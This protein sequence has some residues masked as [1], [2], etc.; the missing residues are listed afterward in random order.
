MKDVAIVIPNNI[1]FCPFVESYKIVLNRLKVDY[2]IISWNRDGRVEEGIQY[3]CALKRISEFHIFMEYQKFIKFVKTEIRKNQYKKIIVI[4]SQPGIFLSSFLISKFKKK[5]IFDFR[6]LSIEQKLIFKY[7]FYRLLSNSFANVISSPGFLNHLPGGKIEYVQ[8][9]N[10]VKEDINKALQ[11]NNFRFQKPKDG[12]I[13]ILTIGGIRDYESNIQII[14]ALANKSKFHLSFVGKGVAAEKL[15]D[16]VDKNSIL[17]VDFEGYYPKSREKEYYENADI[18]NIFYPRTKLHDSAISNR[19]YNSLA[20]RK[21]MI[22]TADTTQGI[23]ASTYNVGLALDD[24]VDLDNK[25][26]TFIN[27]IDAEIYEKNCVMLLEKFVKEY[28]EF[29][30]IIERFVNN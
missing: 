16:Y 5:Y 10:F 12:T 25:L 20:F 22:V 8:T 4:T 18:I 7:P 28:D 30:K 14:K 24:C 23:Y 1:W 21:P 3:N 9:H 11:V 15:H 6:D 26:L 13:N 29:E 17:N 19:F 27:T 2:D